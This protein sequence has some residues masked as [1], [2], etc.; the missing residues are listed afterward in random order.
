VAAALILA[1]TGCSSVYYGTM[2]KMGWHKRD[3]LVSNVK[4]ARDNQ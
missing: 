2:E 1:A 4:E 3:L